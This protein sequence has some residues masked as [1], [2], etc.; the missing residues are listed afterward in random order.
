METRTEWEFFLGA[1]CFASKLATCH[2]LHRKCSFLSV[3]LTIMLNMFVQDRVPLCD[4]KHTCG[5]HLNVAGLRRKL[6]SL[7]P[8]PSLLHRH[9]L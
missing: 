5:K 8:I 6:C 3:T 9:G 1:Y 4:R 7:K 2:Q